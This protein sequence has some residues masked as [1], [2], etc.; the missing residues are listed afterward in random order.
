M[1][2]NQA[3]LLPLLFILTGCPPSAT[4]QPSGG[5]P[6]SNPSEMVFCGEIKRRISKT[7]CEDLTETA[8]ASK[9]GTAAFNVPPMVRGEETTLQLAISLKPPPEPEPSV[10]DY[11]NGTPGSVEPENT[12]EPGISANTTETGSGEPRAPTPK[13]RPKPK[14]PRPSPSPEEP[15]PSAVVEDM[16]GNTVEYYPVVGRHMTAQLVGVGFKIEPEG[17]V[18]QE[19]GRGSVTTW[20]WRVTPLRSPVHTLVIKTAVEGEMADGTRA[21]LASTVKTKEVDVTV[22][23]YHSIWDALVDAPAWIKLVTALLVALTALAGAWWAFVRAARG[24]K[25]DDK[26]K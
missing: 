18:S 1:K 10:E 14:P 2:A 22:R 24:E 13:P 15:S 23:W 5:D 21:P 19:L 12:T 17:P 6:I 3:I 16:A 25:P 8:R 11:D 7:D 20:E 9:A 26:P 4:N